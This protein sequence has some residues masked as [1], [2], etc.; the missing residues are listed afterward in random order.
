[1]ENTKGNLKLRVKVGDSVFIGDVE[2]IV[3]EVSGNSVKLHIRADRSTKI[4]RSNLIDKT[5]NDYD[6]GDTH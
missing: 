2:V 5:A 4:L 1:M 3:S 6:S